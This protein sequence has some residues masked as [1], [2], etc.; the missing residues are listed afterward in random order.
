MVVRFGERGPIHQ[1]LVL[2]EK[3]NGGGGV[4]CLVT[5]AAT[6]AKTCEKKK[7]SN[8]K[9]IDKSLAQQWVT[10]SDAGKPA[11]EKS[12]G[13]GGGLLYAGSFAIK[14]LQEGTDKNFVDPPSG[15]SVESRV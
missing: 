3:K 4:V 9:I 13:F 12:G 1:E 6:S 2:I 5:T 15:E 10:G 14:S 11:A 8:T 7:K